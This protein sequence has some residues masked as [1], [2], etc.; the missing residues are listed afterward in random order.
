MPSAAAAAAA[1]SADP[2]GAAAKRSSSSS[3]PSG[4]TAGGDEYQFGDIT[5]KAISDLTG[6][7][8]YQV[9]SRDGMSCNDWGA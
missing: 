4:T 8:E 3:D 6:K 2:D 5:K 9:R 1:A 7:D